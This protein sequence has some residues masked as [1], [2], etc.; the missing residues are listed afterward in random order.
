[1]IIMLQSIL[2]PPIYFWIEKYEEKST[3]MTAAV[4]WEGMNF[5]LSFPVDQNAVRANMDKKKLVTHMK[6]VVSV[7]VL[8]GKSV[9]DRYNQIDLRLVNDQEAIR[10]KL[11]PVWDKRVDAVNK[12]MRV[13][14]ITREQAVELK[15]L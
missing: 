4:L 11:D 5:G 10:W 7:L 12:L 14:E 1:M 15:L 2:V 13:K 3:I 9:L 6:E 8:H